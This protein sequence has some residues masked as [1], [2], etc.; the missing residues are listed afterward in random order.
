MTPE[1]TAHGVVERLRARIG[2]EGAESVHEVEAGH[3]RR[4]C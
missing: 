1:S 4:F 2:R 3:V